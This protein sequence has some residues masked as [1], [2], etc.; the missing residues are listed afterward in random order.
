MGQ[1]QGMSPCH[2]GDLGHRGHSVTDSVSGLVS[3]SHSSP[4]ISQE[5]NKR[6]AETESL[7]ANTPQYLVVTC[8]QSSVADTTKV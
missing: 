6:K 3:A 2:N 4:V 1:Y 5:Q 8:C 7:A